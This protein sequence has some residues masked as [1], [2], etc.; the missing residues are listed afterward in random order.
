MSKSKHKHPQTVSLPF[1]KGGWIKKSNNTLFNI[2][3]GG[4]VKNTP[5]IQIKTA[6]KLTASDWLINNRYRN[7]LET[8]EI[9][10]IEEA[11][12]LNNIFTNL[13]LSEP[14]SLSIEETCFTT[15]T[16]ERKPKQT[17]RNEKHVLSVLYTF[18]M[19]RP[20][21]GFIASLCP[22]CNTYHIGKL[23]VTEI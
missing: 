16:G 12:R 11:T 6:V 5:V 8:I 18:L 2:G 22:N 15:Y 4:H 7:Q 17:Y 1:V 14:E 19:N 9:I 23:K 21:E 10:T 20:D 13:K 3:W